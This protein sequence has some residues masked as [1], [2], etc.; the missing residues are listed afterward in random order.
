MTH[1]R[2]RQARA[3]VAIVT[4]RELCEIRRH[5]G[6]R[7][8]EANASVDQATF[9]VR[10]IKRA[11]TPVPVAA[12]ATDAR[13]W[14]RE[15]KALGVALTRLLRALHAARHVTLGRAQRKE[16]RAALKQARAACAR[17]GVRRTLG[18]P[19]R[20]NVDV[21]FYEAVLLGFRQA[22]VAMRRAGRVRG[23]AAERVDVAMREAFTTALRP[24]VDN[25]IASTR[26]NASEEYSTRFATALDD[27]SGE[28]LR[29]MRTTT[30]KGPTAA[31]L[32]YVA[33]WHGISVPTLR[34]WESVS[35][36]NLRRNSLQG[37][38]RIALT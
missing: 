15:R 3:F 30:E 2:E 27:A 10:A 23:Q 21:A 5:P 35:R 34:A 9:V 37:I 11:S 8:K 29:D 20:L 13:T 22:H 14:R 31:A 33:R 32:G 24:F 38:D 36:S 28:P 7:S 6:F 4:V 12:T 16:V 1:S 17:A 25:E 19:K 26:A 18:R